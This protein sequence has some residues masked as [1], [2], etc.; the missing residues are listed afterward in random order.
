MTDE[1]MYNCVAPSDLE[2]ATT[3]T[4]LEACS[5]CNCSVSQTDI[6]GPWGDV[7]DVLICLLPFFFLVVTTIVP[8][9]TLPTT[10][11]LPMSALLLFII[12]LTYLGSDPLLASASVVLGL[13]EA[14][15]PLSIMAGAICLFET[16]QATGCMPFIL[17]EMEHLTGS[18]K[19][20]E[21]SLIFSFAYL[22]EGA[23]GFGTPAALCA[24]MLVRMGHPTLESIVVVLLFNTFATVWGAVGTPLWFG[25]GQVVADNTNS[26]DEAEEMLLD[27]SFKAA[28]AL[29]VAAVILLPLI[30]KILVPWKEIRANWLFVTLST[31]STIGPSVGMAF[32]NYEFPSLIGGLVG[33]LVSALLI[34]YRVGLRVSDDEDEQE[35]DDEGQSVNNSKQLSDTPKVESST[36]DSAQEADNDNDEDKENPSIPSPS[37][38]PSFHDSNS[39][40][41]EE[42]HPSERSHRDYDVDSLLGPRKESHE[43]GY[44]KEVIF[45][46][47]PIWAVVLLLVLTRVEQVGLKERLTKQTPYFDIHFGTLGTFRLSSSLVIQM[48]DIM[49]YPNLNWKYELLYI[50]FIMPF[51]IVSI[52]TMILFRKELTCKPSDIFVTVGKRLY[53]PAIALMGALVLVQLTIRT[54]SMAPAFI[55]GTVLA[56]WFQEGFVIVSPLL[57]ALGAFFS[58]SNTVSNL[59]FGEIQTIAA[60]NVGTSSTA[61]LALQTVGASAGNGI[62]L[63]NI[64][65]ACAVVGMSG[66]GAEGKILLQTYKYVLASTTISTVVMLTLFFRF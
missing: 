34:H 44:L 28:I 38:Q 66:A 47:F 53:N 11:S 29:A 55:L 63:N 31:A 4:T 27:I 5:D 41:H 54:G 65:A 57:G 60:E 6:G 25:F 61:M 14:M 35:L 64:I 22:L 52:L 18:S 39:S 51:V 36:S 37:L 58:G 33:C 2:C 26:Q 10:Q 9:W 48:R 15:T 45:R 24:P 49:T 46:T 23:S 13:L 42:P 3:C 40:N 19:L 16:M 12:R 8:R 59:T 21:L 56:D 30:L 32:V 20:A 62:C 50:P 17:R 43:P 1:S 7:M